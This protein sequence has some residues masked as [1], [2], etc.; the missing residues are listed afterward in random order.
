MSAGFGGGS[1]CVWVKTIPVCDTNRERERELS[2][3]GLP[4]AGR[5][6]VK[7]SRFGSHDVNHSG[8]DR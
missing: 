2:H 4:Y 6:G 3:Y 7:P 1:V 8:L 5:F